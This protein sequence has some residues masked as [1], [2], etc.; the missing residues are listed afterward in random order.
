MRYNGRSIDKQVVFETNFFMY[1]GYV[2]QGDRKIDDVIHC[3]RLGVG[4]KWRLT[5]TVFC[6][7]NVS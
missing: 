2:I 3:I 1:L 6:D 7:K 5:F 4:V